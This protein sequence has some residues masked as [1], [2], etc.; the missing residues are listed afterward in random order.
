VG[1]LEMVMKTTIKIFEKKQE[2]AVPMLMLGG[3]EETTEDEEE[4]KD[5][6][7]MSHGEERE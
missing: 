7:L 1:I 6:E 2:G 3:N 5:G 4:K